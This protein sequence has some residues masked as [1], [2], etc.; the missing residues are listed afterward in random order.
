MLSW[1]D[2]PVVRARAHGDLPG[3]KDIPPS[4]LPLAQPPAGGATPATR[5][6]RPPLKRGGCSGRPHRT[7]MCLYRKICPILFDKPCPNTQ[8]IE[9][10]KPALGRGAGAPTY[11]EAIGLEAQR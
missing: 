9:S 11:E 10:S 6:A 8:V 3:F 4:I 5:D 2:N 1:N 7:A